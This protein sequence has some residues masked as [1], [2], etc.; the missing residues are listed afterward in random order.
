MGPSNSIRTTKVAT[1]TRF[2]AY[3][4]TV[5]NYCYRTTHVRLA[6]QA[7]LTLQLRTIWTGELWPNLELSI[8]GS[9]TLYTSQAWNYVFIVGRRVGNGLTNPYL[10]ER[11][12]LSDRQYIDSI[13]LYNGNTIWSLTNS[14]YSPIIF[15]THIVT[16]LPSCLPWGQ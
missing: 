16:Y 12:S 5:I 13:S 8:W 7:G 11:I 14:L 6:L 3:K 1:C 15:P 2:T 4:I 10:T 9:R